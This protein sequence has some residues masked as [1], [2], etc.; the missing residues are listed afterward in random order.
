MS[1]VSIRT[2]NVSKQYRIGS[3]QK[4]YKTFRETITDIVVSPFR[5]LRGDGGLR[6]TSET[7]WALKDVSFEIKQGEVLGVIGHN[8]AGKTT[9]LKIISRITEPTQGRVELY[10][11]VGSLL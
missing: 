4:G 8:G 3:Q 1:D 7:F 5:R 6:P 11:R 9:L 10:G 2:Q